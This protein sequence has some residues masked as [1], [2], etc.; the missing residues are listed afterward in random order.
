MLGEFLIKPIIQDFLE[1][2][3]TKIFLNWSRKHI[4]IVIW[5]KF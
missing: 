1:E 2:E 3:N 5:C 4:Y